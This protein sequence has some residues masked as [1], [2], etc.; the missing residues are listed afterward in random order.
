MIEY[1]LSP[2]TVEA[3]GWTLLHS[4]WQGAIFALVLVFVLILL[5]R[6]TAQSRYVVAVGLLSAFF[7]TISATFAMQWKAANANIAMSEK[8]AVDQ[9]DNDSFTLNNE[10]L[11]LSSNTENENAALFGENIVSHQSIWI[12]KFKS[13]Y[14]QHLPLLVTLWFLGLLFLQLRFLGQLAYVQRLKH[15]G[16]QLFPEAW[17]D[18]IEELEGKLRIQKKVKYLTS[19]RIE[20]PMVVGWLKPVVLMPQQLFHSLSETEI[21]AV[22]AH[23]LA[24][25][26]RED[27]IVNLIQTFLCNIFFFHPGV[28]WMSNRIDDEREHCCDD[29]AV[30]ATGPAISYAKTLINVSEYQ[31]KLQDNPTLAVAF[32]GK[33]NKRERGGFTG[34]IRRLFNVNKGSSTF[35]EGFATALILITALSLA[36]AATGR[37]IQVTETDIN[38]ESNKIELSNPNNKQSTGE[39][40]PISSITTTTITTTTSNPSIGEIQPT[41][42]LVGPPAPPP[43]PAPESPNSREV[44]S[45]MNACANGDFET[46]KQ[47]INSGVDINSIGAERFTPLMMAVSND[48]TKIVEYLIIAGANVNQSFNGWTA[49]IEAAD[50]GSYS[51]MKLLLKAGAEV[52]YYHRIH[53]PTAISMAASEGHLNC[54]QLLLENGANINGVGNSIPP[55]HMAAEEN[56]KSILDYL[57]A[58]KVKINKKDALGRTALMY[59]ASEGNKYAVKKL[60]ESG[61][62]YSITDSNND[63]AR[64]YAIE[65]YQNDVRD[66][67]T[68]EK[69]PSI[70]QATFDGLIEKVE[71]MVEQGA[72]VN[73]RDNVGRTPLHIAAAENHTLDMRVLFNLGADLNAKDGQ[74]RTPMMYAAADGKADAVT[75]LVSQQANVQLEDEDG[76]RAYDWA[77]SSGNN[78]LTSFLGL[79]TKDRNK[80]LRKGK[81]RDQQKE[82]V[83]EQRIEKELEKRIEKIIQ[84]EEQKETFHINENSTHLKQFNIE[85]KKLEL[86]EAIKSGSISKCRE[87]LRGGSSANDSDDTGQTPLMIA[88]RTNQLTI[89]KLLIEQ[90]ADVNKSSVAGLTALH[91]AA[92]ENRA[93]IAKILLRNNANIDPIMRYSSTDG[94]YSNKPLVWE[95]IGATPLLIAVESKNKEVLKVLITSGAD[96][97]HQLTRNEYLLKSDRA[98]Y[99][100]GS[101]VMGID[102]DFLKN[103]KVKVSDDSW[104][105]YKQAVHLNDPT[106]LALF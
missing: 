77:R 54:L 47:L 10:N 28:W 32:S 19:I 13:Y 74:G 59:A 100:D 1:L 71:R 103:I 105:P 8:N 85:E 9:S 94:N 101:E 36:V 72:D 79:I 92:L 4:L 39:E 45:L 86:I 90:G 73:A 84:K 27:F 51:S 12:A 5:K 57:I 63:T 7:L 34:R 93:E 26:R 16:T 87:L 38:S 48:E 80:F 21:Y 60:V 78:Q 25:I 61:A 55:L 22:L 3:L 2:Q 66:Y 6:Y 99:L 24:H 58:Q 50:E 91:Y 31:L 64:D 41:N 49:L 18:K 20:S 96:K 65:E 83:K 46:V 44:E 43:P 68:N 81:N 56:K 98:S 69:R 95:Y 104:T 17:S 11:D 14:D 75:L 42:N 102:Q 53:S 30:A 76:M 40:K 35:G 23:E 37:T 106:V 67:L 97:N 89:V 70:H 62:D 52:N 15:Y 88:T 29:L 82:E 33:N